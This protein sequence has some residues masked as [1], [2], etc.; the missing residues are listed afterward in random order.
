[1]LLYIILGSECIFLAFSYNLF[2]WLLHLFLRQASTA[3]SAIRIGSWW[4]SDVPSIHAVIARV[5]FQ[6][7]ILEALVLSRELCLQ[8]VQV[9]LHVVLDQG[10]CGARI[11]QLHT[12]LLSHVLHVEAHQARFLILIDVKFGA[13][14]PGFRAAEDGI[15]V[16]SDGSL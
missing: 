7:D 3:L 10:G 4:I 5:V 15:F 13:Q 16:G 6:I 14:F 12:L 11:W 2:L 8:L 1:M 9:D